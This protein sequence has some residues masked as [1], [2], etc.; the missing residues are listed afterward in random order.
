MKRK[1]SDRIPQDIKQVLEQI[2]CWRQTKPKPRAMPEHL[3]QD[4]VSLVP[5]YG[6]YKVSS[7]LN[8]GYTK[9]KLLTSQKQSQHQ[10]LDVVVHEALPPTEFVSFSPSSLFSTPEL[11]PN[12]LELSSTD[13]RSLVIRTHQ[14]LD[15]D[16]LIHSF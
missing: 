12:V 16:S 8:V 4:A 15:L 13:G 2:E 6:P 5:K 9:L 14:P 1:K 7:L 11:P 3:W 10:T